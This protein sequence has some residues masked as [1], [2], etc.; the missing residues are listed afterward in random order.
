MELDAKPRAK[1]RAKTQSRTCSRM[2]GPRA[3][4]EFLYGFK[5]APAARQR[6]AS[7]RQY[8]RRARAGR[9]GE[10]ELRQ[11]APPGRWRR[12]RR[13][14]VRSQ[15]VGLAR[16]L[17]RGA[18]PSP[19]R[20]RPA[21]VPA[22][23]RPV[24]DRRYAAPGTAPCESRGWPVLRAGHRLAGKVTVKGAPAA[25]RL[26]RNRRPLSSDLARQVI[27]TYRKDGA[28]RG[29]PALLRCFPGGG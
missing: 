24:V 11:A 10:R 15:G 28:A 21:A 4:Y 16:P 6:R 20:R 7:A 29:G 23:A 3:C 1:P 8:R 13:G 2:P 5:G 18:L 17:S 26:L 14:P 22:T 27:G 19:R 9:E 25:R 12:R